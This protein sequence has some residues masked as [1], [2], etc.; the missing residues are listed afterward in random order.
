MTCLIAGASG[1]V[2][3]EL[4]KI[5]LQDPQFTKIVS[6]AR[7]ELPVQ[8]EKLAQ[9]TT[10]LDKVEAFILPASEVAFCCLGT[11]ISKAGSQDNFK[12]VDHEYVIRF[13]RASKKAGVKK[14]LV[15][16]ALGADADSSVFYN[17]IK[18]ETE[19]DLKSLKFE[20]LLIFQPSLLLGERAES[21]PL[22]KFAIMSAPLLN[23]LLVGPLAKYKPISAQAVAQSM[24]KKAKEPSSLIE[25]IPNHEMLP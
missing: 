10:P 13:A 12:L 25:I 19:R 24:M 6:M 5:L 8:N 9:I 3:G 4:L 23:P 1:L 7:R 22:E 17:R 20:S 11:T 16:S 14:F 15:V 21:R 2:G 18:G